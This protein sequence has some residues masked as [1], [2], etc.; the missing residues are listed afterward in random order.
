MRSLCFT[1]HLFEKD[2]SYTINLQ[3]N[4]YFN[5]SFEK[6]MWISV[7]TFLLQLFIYYLVI[8]YKWCKC[9]RFTNPPPPAKCKSLCTEAR[10]HKKQHAYN[11]WE[12]I[13]TNE[14]AKPSTT[15]NFIVSSILGIRSKIYRK[16]VSNVLMV[17]ST[18]TSYPR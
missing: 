3:H 12:Y 10:S 18:W 11:R 17:P 16:T 6:K 8:L 4:N 14:D 7:L 5:Y 2:M 9:F 1:G 13:G 15:V